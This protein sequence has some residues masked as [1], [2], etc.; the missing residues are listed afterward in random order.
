MPQRLA[1][2][3]PDFAVI[4]DLNFRIGL[5]IER[6][7]NVPADFASSTSCVACDCF[8][9]R[10]ASWTGCGGVPV[11]R[12]TVARPAPQQR[13]PCEGFDSLQLFRSHSRRVLSQKSFVRSRSARYSNRSACSTSAAAE[14][15]VSMSR[16]RTSAD[17]S[18][19]VRCGI[20]VRTRLARSR[21]SSAPSSHRNA[22]AHR[23]MRTGGGGNGWRGLAD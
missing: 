6:M 9:H 12:K 16:S 2:D 5:V 8:D 13:H 4:T 3:R 17:N 11:L 7:E 20:A 18:S 1:L 14:A 23:S 10:G 15:T 22:R 19:P 21:R